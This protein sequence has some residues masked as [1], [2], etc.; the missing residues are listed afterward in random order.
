MVDLC[1][2]YE[3]YIACKKFISSIGL[4]RGANTGLSPVWG[5]TGT[6]HDVS[7]NADLHFYMPSNRARFKVVV[8]MNVHNK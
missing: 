8:I 7:C 6:P 5:L 2:N 3:D 4:R 1:V